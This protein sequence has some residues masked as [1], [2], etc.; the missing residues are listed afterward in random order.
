MSHTP[1]SGSPTSAPGGR[2][3]DPDLTERLLAR[4][5]DAIGVA[6]LWDELD[7]GWPLLDAELLPWSGKA[8]QLPVAAGIDW[9]TDLTAAGG[10]GMVV[11]PFDGLVHGAH[12]LVQPGIK[13]G[14]PEYLSI[15]YGPTTP[16]RTTSPG[17]GRATSVASDP[18]PCASTSSARK[19]WTGW[20]PTNR[21]GGCTSACSPCWRWNP[22][23]STR[24]PR[25]TDPSTE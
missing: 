7:T 2:F 20:P 8:G 24:A 14:G 12:G 11:K 17:C 1:D 5:R 19:R 25:G 6:G 9:W 16:S 4:V 21:Y 3:A 23:Q 15:I 13:C 22:N 10:E 18:R